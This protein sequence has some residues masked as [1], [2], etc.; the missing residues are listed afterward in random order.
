MSTNWPEIIFVASLAV[1]GGRADERTTALPCLL[2]ELPELP[3]AAFRASA[4]VTRPGSVARDR[5]TLAVM[6]DVCSS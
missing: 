5:A 4:V 1:I 6:L 2:H 3:V